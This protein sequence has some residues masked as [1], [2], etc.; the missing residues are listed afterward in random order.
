MADELDEL[1]DFLSNS[2][3]QVRGAAADIVRG[4]TG[5]S[6]GLRSLAARADRALPALL[7]LL[8]SVGGGGAGEAAADSLVNLSQDGDLAA[9]LVVLGAVAA[10]MDVMV[11]RGGEQPKL[12]RSLVMLLVNLTQ[13]ES[14]ISALL[15][16]GDEKVQGLYVAKL[17][18][19]FCRSSCDSEDEDIFEHIAS[20]LVNISKVEAGRRILMEPKRGLL[21]QIIG[22]FDSTNQLRK[23]GVA[24]TIRNCCFEAD[25]QIQNLLSIAEYLWPALLLPVAGK[26]IYSEEDRSKMPPELANALSHEREAVD[27][28]EIRERALEA[29]YM[30]VMQDDGRKAFW[31]VNGPRILQV[32]YED[33]EDLKVMGAYELIGSLVLP[34]NF[35]M[36]IFAVLHLNNECFAFRITYFVCA[37]LQ[38]S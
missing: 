35:G 38:S 22:Q 10:A 14:G 11:K 23:K 36:S 9:R 2:S 27:D 12:A 25:T 21:K 28:S 18:R 15:Q 7:R 37:H 13:V 5:D 33:E 1:I 34:L 4:L 6:D 30:I 8:A 19:S 17:V 24:G 16:V 32:G 26:K 29:I 31:S 3:P 20:I